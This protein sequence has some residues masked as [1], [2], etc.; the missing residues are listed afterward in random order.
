MAQLLELIAAV[1]EKPHL[2]VTDDRPGKHETGI[3]AIH[4]LHEEYNGDTIPALLVGGDVDPQW[5]VEV[6]VRG[7][8]CC[9]SRWI[10]R[11]CAR[12]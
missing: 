1:P 9:T 6:A 5:L 3:K 11:N 10:L 2:I 4:R 7:W 8:P 12:R